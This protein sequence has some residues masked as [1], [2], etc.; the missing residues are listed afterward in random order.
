MKR[1]WALMARLI[2]P[3]LRRKA[4]ANAGAVAIAVGVAVFVPSAA[5]AE[6]TFFE[7]CADSNV[8][9]QDGVQVSAP[10]VYDVCETEPNTLTRVCFLGAGDYIFVKDGWADG[11]SAFAKVSYSPYHRFCRNKYTAGTWVRC[12]F[13]W[14]EDA[15]K[16][17][18]GGVVIDRNTSAY[19]NLFW[20][21]SG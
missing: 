17:I 2:P 18:S 21:Y 16:L 6:A 12:N 9:C 11:R 5:W 14:N 10:T 20:I 8:S 3:A 7:V 13:D 1:F 4:A 15:D 19:T